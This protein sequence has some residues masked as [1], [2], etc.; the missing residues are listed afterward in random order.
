MLTEDGS[1]TGPF[2]WWRLNQSKF[3]SIWELAIHI[4]AIAATSVPAESVF[5]AAAK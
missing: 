5:S 2:I 1:Y 4:L 3:P